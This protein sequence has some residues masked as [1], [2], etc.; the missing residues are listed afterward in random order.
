MY[1]LFFSLFGYRFPE[2]FKNHHM[3]TLIL[4]GIR[5]IEMIDK[6]VPVLKNATDVLIRMITV[7]VCGS[8]IH[9]FAAGKIGTQVVEFP[10]AVGHECSGM[11]EETGSAVT[12]VKTGDLVA[13]DPSVHCGV[14]D[15]CLAG[16]PHIPAVKTCSWAVPDN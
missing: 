6:P 3:K 15:Q 8:D 7:G 4:T 13:I 16:R 1:Q 2:N 12:R 10:F 9:Y 11:V 14:C 5:K